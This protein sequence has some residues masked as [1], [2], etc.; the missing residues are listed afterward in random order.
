MPSKK[1][2]IRKTKES[3]F[4]ES[5]AELESIIDSIEEEETPLEELVSK[6]EQG[7]RLLIHCESV[8]KSA[9]KRLET[10]T[11]Q[12]ADSSEENTEDAGNHLTDNGSTGTDLPDDDD[13]IRLF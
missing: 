2:S 5:I 11:N 3:T 12:N 13:D 1:A 6:Y 7:T 4:E 9:R 10:L 8:L